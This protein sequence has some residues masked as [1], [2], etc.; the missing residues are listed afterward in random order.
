MQVI[1]AEP[2]QPIYFI[3][4]GIPNA[5]DTITIGKIAPPTLRD[6]SESS[7]CLKYDVMY[8]FTEP[9]RNTVPVPSARKKPPI[10]VRIPRKCIDKVISG[11]F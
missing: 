3:P 2:N 5:K 7:F 10:S 9:H 4:I 8:T 1:R 11:I 6:N